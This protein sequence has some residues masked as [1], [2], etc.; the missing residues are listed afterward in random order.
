[1]VGGCATATNLRHIQ[2]ILSD[3]YHI[4]AVINLTFLMWIV[5]QINGRACL[6]TSQI[7]RLALLAILA[8]S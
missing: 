7:V 8:S 4:L 1:M 3:C 5:L 2:M 6:V